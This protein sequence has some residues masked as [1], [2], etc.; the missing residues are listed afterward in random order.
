MEICSRTIFSKIGLLSNGPIQRSYK[1]SGDFYFGDPD[2]SNP[3][4]SEFVNHKGFNTLTVGNHDDCAT[5]IAGDSVFRNPNSP[6]ADRELQELVAN[7]TGV[8]AVG[9]TGSGTSFAAPAVAGAV[10]VVQQANPV[11][12][13]WPEGC[14]A[15]LLAATD[16]RTTLS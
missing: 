10:A 11:L 8:M 5:T 7:G 9:V 13:S 4:S 12:R 16:R 15:K 6:H 3:P 1:A 14:R 2:N